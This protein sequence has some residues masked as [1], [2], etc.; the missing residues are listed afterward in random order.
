MAYIF[1]DESGDL[2]FDFSKKKTS[3]YFVISFLFVANKTPVD[4]II[5]KVFKHFSKK[6]I[7]NH[8]GILHC[9]KEKPKIRQ[10]VLKSIKEKD[11]S[12]IS[13]YLNKKKVYTKLQ[14]EKHVLYNYVTNI[15]I[16]RVCTKKLIPTNEPIRLIASRRETNKFLNHNFCSYIQNQVQNNHKLDIKVEIKPP[17]EERCLQAV[18]FICWAIYRKIEHGDDSYVNLIKQKIV[19]E[20]PLFP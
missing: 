13:I 11:V 15:L 4:R 16:D 2:G 10:F 12:I 18:D 17:Y 1:L 14:D 8:H 19:E 5:K 20:S 9:Y 7:K 3:K 6:E